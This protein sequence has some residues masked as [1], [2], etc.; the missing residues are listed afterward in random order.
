MIDVLGGKCQ[1]LSNS[2]GPGYKYIYIYTVLYTHMCKYL[3]ASDVYR[4]VSVCSLVTSLGLTGLND[5]YQ[6]I[7][8][9]YP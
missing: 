8:D 2:V 3:S 7:L 5:A 6:S 4:L 9:D 1:S